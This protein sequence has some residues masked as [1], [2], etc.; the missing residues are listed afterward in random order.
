MERQRTAKMKKS[1]EEMEKQHVV[2]KEK[3]NV[4]RWVVMIDE[5]SFW[6]SLH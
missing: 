6:S 2:E 3:Q 4:A 1:V 5:I